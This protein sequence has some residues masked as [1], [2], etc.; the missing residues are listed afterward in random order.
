MIYAHSNSV[1]LRNKIESLRSIA[2]DEC[3]EDEIMGF[4][5]LQTSEEV[6]TSVMKVRLWRLVVSKLRHRPERIKLGPLD[7]TEDCFDRNLDAREIL[8]EEFDGAESEGML[9]HDTLF[10][11]GW[12]SIEDDALDNG[13]F[14]SDELTIP[15]LDDGLFVSDELTMLDWND[16]LFESEGP[17]MLDLENRVSFEDEDYI[18]R[19][20][21]TRHV[22]EPAPYSPVEDILDD[23]ENLLPL[24]DFFLDHAPNFPANFPANSKY[25][26]GC[27]EDEMLMEEVVS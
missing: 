22:Y 1:N 20:S 7:W 2:P 6:L 26:F 4:R 9:N 25:Q 19:D 11:E 15:E 3:L 14:E 13:L 5:I 24:D 18:S 21:F 23:N 8:E 17:T 16:G 27:E 12:L 10:E